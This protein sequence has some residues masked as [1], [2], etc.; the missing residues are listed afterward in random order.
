MTE[1][2]AQAD[3]Q[4][5]ANRTGLYWWVIRLKDKSYEA[6][7]SHHMITHKA[8]YNDGTFKVISKRFEKQ[9]ETTIV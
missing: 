2:E 6:V 1:K 9:N 5:R 8:K 4:A 7:Q 3:A